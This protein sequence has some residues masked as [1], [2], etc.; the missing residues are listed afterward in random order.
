[1]SAVLAYLSDE[2]PELAKKVARDYSCF[3][4]FGDDAQRK[5]LLSFVQY[6]S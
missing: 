3:D 4:K 6:L 2:D 1:M 5:S